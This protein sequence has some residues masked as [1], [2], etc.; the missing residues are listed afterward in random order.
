M[1]VKRLGETKV[2]N[3]HMSIQQLLT[4]RESNLNEMEIHTVQRLYICDV[5]VSISNFDTV[6]ATF[7]P[8]LVARIRT[9]VLFDPQKFVLG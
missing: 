3:V 8:V 4:L 1:L 5:I 2:P 7:P 6:D 9:Q